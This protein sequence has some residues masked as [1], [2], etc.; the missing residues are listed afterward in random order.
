MKMEMRYMQDVIVEKATMHLLDTNG[1]APLLNS[2]DIELN[3]RSYEFLHKQIIKGLN[4]F[5]NFKGKLFGSDG[6]MYKNITR[7]IGEEGAFIESTQEMAKHLFKTLKKYDGINSCNLVACKFSS[8]NVDFLALLELDYQT[9]FEHDIDYED[10][11]FKIKLVTQETGLPGATQKIS[12]LAFFKMPS[13]DYYDAIY[14]EK[15]F[16]TIE[17]ETVRYFRDEFLQCSQVIDDTGATQIVKAQ[18]EKW[19]RKTLKDDIDKA[20]EIRD[21]INDTFIHSGTL[22]VEA[23]ASSITDNNEEKEMFLEEMEKRGVDITEKIDI[24]KRWVEKKMKSKQIKTDT[25]FNI[26][27]DYDFFNDSMR[28]EIKYNGDGSVNYI[29][30]NVRNVSER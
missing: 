25:G 16:K 28:F 29:I 21:E 22:D 17:N 19:V 26:K 8:D 13:D 3:H 11:K 9:L 10:D 15:P 6:L 24:D 1:D 7:A 2:F 18:V 30:K 12:N 27:G 23:L 5:N 14:L 20:T 4:D